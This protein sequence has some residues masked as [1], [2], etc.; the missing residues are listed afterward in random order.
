MSINIKYVDDQMECIISDIGDHP[1]LNNVT[2]DNVEN[3]LG[4]YETMSQMFPY[5][6]AKAIGEA[7]LNCIKN[8]LTISSNV[9]KTS[10]VGAFLVSDEMGVY[11][12]ANT[13]GNEGLP[14]ILNTSENFHFNMLKDDVS[15][16]LGFVI[17]PGYSHFT[18][19]YMDNLLRLLSSSDDVKR[20]ATMVAF[21]AHAENMIESLWDGLMKLYPELDK[22]TLNYFRVHVGGDDPAEAYHV[23]MTNQLI[24]EVVPFG[25]EKL[26]LD[27]FEEAY[28]VNYNW[29][30]E[31]T[32]Y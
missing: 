26:F 1:F 12:I 8:H 21:E 14:T 28:Q 22:E 20:V 5:I 23:A 30:D 13:L 9:E 11:H 3:I 24:T 7:A 27:N 2:K 25:E 19:K 29:C 18:T 32:K 31:I 6:Q 4:E 16:R 15:N 17:E 10:A